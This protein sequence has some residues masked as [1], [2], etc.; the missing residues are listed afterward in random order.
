MSNHR[1]RGEFPFLPSVTL[2]CTRAIIIL[3]FLVNTLRHGHRISS[4]HFSRS[5]QHE[6]MSLQPDV[7]DITAWRKERKSQ[8]K[9][10][11]GERRI[12]HRS[13]RTET[14]PSLTVSR[15]SPSPFWSM[16]RSLD[17]G[18]VEVRIRK[19]VCFDVR[20]EPPD[21]RRVG[22]VGRYPLASTASEE[23]TVSAAAVDDDR[24][25]ISVCGEDP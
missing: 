11:R 9:T 18:R 23:A 17:N 13:K 14:A 12:S 20:E 16:S 3:Y 22:D 25:R 2:D 5:N 24:P 8:K 21:G 15:A 19:S 7:R 4:S 10:K 6:Q 1:Q